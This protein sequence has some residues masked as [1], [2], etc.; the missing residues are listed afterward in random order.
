M[1]DATRFQEFAC[2]HEHRFAIPVGEVLAE[3]RP[4]CC[5]QCG[6]S[7]VTAVPPEHS[8]DEAC[9]RV[10]VG[11]GGD[12]F[13]PVCE[14]PGG[15]EG[16]CKSTDAVDAA[17]K[18]TDPDGDW[19]DPRALLRRVL[20]YYPEPPSRGLMADAEACLEHSNDEV[21]LREV[22]AVAA[23]RLTY[24]GELGAAAAAMQRERDEARAAVQRLCEALEPFVEATE[25]NRDRQP[26][27]RGEIEIFVDLVDA[28]RAAAALAA[29]CPTSEQ[30]T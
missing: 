16:V 23:Q 18:L 15:H 5:A 30:R 8:N 29:S 19:R 4:L 28:H 9:G 1:S 7:S 11:L 10:M 14:L 24:N 3:A 2:A 20:G 22:E 25:S 27:G 6:T 21:E 26:D 17:H 13:D 12:T